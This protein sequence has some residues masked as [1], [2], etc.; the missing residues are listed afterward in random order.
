[1]K[2]KMK[3]IMTVTYAAFAMFV[4]GCFGFS[5]SAQAVSPPPDGGYP[6]G[7]TAEGQ[8]ALLSLTSGTLNTAVGSFSLRSV[9]AGNLNTATGAGALFANT[10]DQNTATGAEALL[11]NTTGTNN[12]GDGT[13]TLANNTAGQGNTAIGTGAL[14]DNTIASQNTAVGNS[15]LAHNTTGNGNTADSFGAL[16]NNSTGNE[17]TAIGDLAGFNQTTGGNNVYIGSA[18]TGVA[19]ESNACY[20]ASIF[21]QASA[22]GVQVLIDSDNKLGTATSSK[23]FKENIRT[24]GRTS[25]ALFSLKPVSFRYKKELDPVG[26]SQLGLVAEDVEKVNRDLVVRDKQGKAYSVRYD[27]V[28]AMLLNEFLKEHREV[29]K[30]KQQV[31]ALTVSLQKMSAQTET[32]QTAPE[33]VAH[34][35]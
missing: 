2:K 16:F 19:G 11:S 8:N 13:F 1:M 25:E 29:Q 4:L 10:G 23:R 24:M 30:L 14:F 33:M 26:I 17:N 35:Q 32:K 12:T 9:R 15:A 18:V 27:Q 5:Q 22:N 28:N 6:G 7:N 3:R 21:G 20:I 34:N 31:A